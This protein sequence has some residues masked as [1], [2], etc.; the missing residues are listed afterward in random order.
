M[1]VLLI[2]M[3]MGTA[4]MASGQSGWTT[5]GGG[6]SDEEPSKIAALKPRVLST[7]WTK[8]DSFDE[9]SEPASPAP[10]IKR[11]KRPKAGSRL[12]GLRALITLAESHKRGY[13]A[14][15]GSATRLPAKR[16]TELTIA[17]ILAWI[18]ETPG[19]HHA[20]G[21][22]QIIPDTLK[23]LIVRSG[24]SPTMKFTPEVQDHLGDIL[25]ADAGYNDFVAGKLPASQLMDNL[26][27][28]WAGFP[29]AN[30]RSAYHGKAGNRAT[31]T[32]AFFQ[33]ELGRVFGP[34]ESL[35]R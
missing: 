34:A 13:D 7:I 5:L 4:E 1:I 9:R 10:D 32:R 33:A 12:K 17:Q 26:A 22:Y 2:C 3:G 14:I 30:G 23:S 24:I 27:K 21:F 16:P 18:E 35:L 8:G 31:I 25:L 29:M 20:I 19:Q 6:W 15:H 11:W 28:I